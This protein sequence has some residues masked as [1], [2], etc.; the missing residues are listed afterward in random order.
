MLFL[1]WE[2]DRPSAIYALTCGCTLLLLGTI[3]DIVGSQP[4]YLLGNLLQTAF[5]FG[6]GLSKTG[7]QMIVLRGLGGIASSFCLPSAVSIITNTFSPG[8]RRSIAFGSMGGGLPIGFAI[9]LVLGGACADTIGWQWGFNIIAMI[10]FVILVLLIWQ[11]PKITRNTPIVSWKRLVFDID[12]I[13]VMI[14]SLAL[15]VLSY[16]LV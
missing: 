2:F 5:T 16:D 12:W 1:T 6:S 3:T 9:G 10:N 4:I 14:I 11:L 7:T 13:G 15:A 8:R